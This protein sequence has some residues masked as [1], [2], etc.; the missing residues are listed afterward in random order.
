MLFHILSFSVNSTL[1]LVSK[2]TTMEITTTTTS[3]TT[4]STVHFGAITDRN[5]EKRYK[6][7]LAKHDNQCKKTAPQ[8]EPVEEASVCVELIRDRM[9]RRRCYDCTLSISELWFFRPLHR[10]P[11]D[12]ICVHKCVGCGAGRSTCSNCS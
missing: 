6:L 10:F 2:R 4:K 7:N 11:I 8:S 5:V 12:R 9:E 1:T 3:T